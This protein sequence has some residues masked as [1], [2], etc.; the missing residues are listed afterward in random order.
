MKIEFVKS[1]DKKKILEKLEQDFGIEK[2]NFLLI[3]S[4]KDKIRGFTGS[5][6]KDEILALSRNANIEVIGL[7]LFK[8]ENGMRLSFDAPFLLK[9]KK[10]IVEISGEQ[11]ENWLKGMNI[12]IEIDKEGFVVLKNKQDFLGCG[13][14][15][16]GRIANFVPKERRIKS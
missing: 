7:Y 1:S 8:E 11:A 10:N 2:L 5:L 13:K 4:G 9:A 12:E 16:Q 14:A 6:S 3:K 15:S